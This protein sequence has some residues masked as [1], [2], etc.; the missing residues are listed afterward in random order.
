MAWQVLSED[1][2][3]HIATHK[4][5][6]GAYTPLDNV[7]NPFWLQLVEFL[8]K[9]FAPNLVTLSGFLPIVVSYILA[10]YFSPDFSTP[11]PRWVAVLTACS[12]FLYQT[13]DA[14][15]GK[16][17]RRIGASTPLG[18]LFD[19]GC[20]CL[21]TLSH[22]SMAA[23][24]FLPGSSRSGIAGLA[25]M[26][27][28]FFLAQWQER[29]TGVL[30]TSFGAVGVTETQFSLMVLALF[31]GVLGPDQVKALAA[32]EVQVPWA[33]I[34]MSLGQLACLGWVLFCILMSMICLVKTI[35]HVA[36]G[37]SEGAGT[38]VQQLLESTTYLLPVVLLNLFLF[39]WQ[40]SV[41]EKAPRVICLVVGLLF[42]FYTAQMILF[43]MARMS[44]PVVQP[45]LIAFGCLTIASRLA[46]EQTHLILLALKAF[47]ALLC[48]HVFIWLATAIA[49]LK[50]KLRIYAFSVA[51]P[52]AK[53]K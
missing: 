20:D 44:F 8:P 52:E 22:H 5:K 46:P 12:L 24:V 1:G 11:V 7:L 27:T 29:Y 40:P 37:L 53:T 15:D 31:A 10:W 39:A 49:E 33:S 47:A 2:L 50:S 13:L 3:G 26:Q 25:A 9:W 48:V 43:S 34:S 42:F 36:S 21:A 45:T 28:G 14:L 41:V 35:T 23:L 16:Q 6:P 17:A 19:H 38:P 51:S 18:Q 4:Y 32:S 30:R